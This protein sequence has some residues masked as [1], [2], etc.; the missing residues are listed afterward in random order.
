MPTVLDIGVGTGMLSALCLRFGAKH[1]TAAS[2]A[3]R[4]CCRFHFR[5]AAT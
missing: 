5:G 3:T 1:V 4:R 2:T